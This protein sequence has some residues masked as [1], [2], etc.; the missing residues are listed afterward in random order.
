MAMYMKEL[1]PWIRHKVRVIIVKQWKR[2]K[3]IYR[4]LMKLNNRLHC[5]FSREDIYRVAN[6][7]LGLYK[8]CGMQ[9][10]NFLLSPEILETPS[11]KM[12]RPALINP[13]EYY[14]KV[15]W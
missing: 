3:T 6:T 4:N 14:L 12:N 5:N 8:Q 11:E 2:P 10:I 13:Y 9:V 15:H 7:R 1:G